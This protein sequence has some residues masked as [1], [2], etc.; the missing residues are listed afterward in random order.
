MSFRD[1]SNNFTK[2]LNMQKYTKV[3]VLTYIPNKREHDPG[4]PAN[5]RGDAYFTIPCF[6]DF[7]C[8]L[9][10]GNLHQK[11]GKKMSQSLYSGGNTK[12]FSLT[13]NKSY[14]N[15]KHKLK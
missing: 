2:S 6:Q 14:N 4:T 1:S 12:I 10:D 7:D 13:P 9:S 11:N 3:L 5:I 15:Y 8:P